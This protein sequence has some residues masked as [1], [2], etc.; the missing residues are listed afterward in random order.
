MSLLSS[1]RFSPPERPVTAHWPGSQR[2]ID[3][4]PDDCVCQVPVPVLQA[5]SGSCVTGWLR[6]L[7]YR[8]V[9]V[10][11]GVDARR[12]AASVG[13]R[14]VLTAGVVSD[15][16]H[17]EDFAAGGDLHGLADDG[18]LDLATPMCS[19]SMERYSP[20][21]KPTHLV[22]RHARDQRLAAAEPPA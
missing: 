22:N 15:A 19:A 1:N 8:S 21:V 9:R 18:D 10:S 12:S 16:V 6:W 14:A 2:D 3:A 11:G 17:P 7:C 5:G 13:E 20:L 4:A